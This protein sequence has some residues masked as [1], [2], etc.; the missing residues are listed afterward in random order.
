LQKATSGS[1][2][3]ALRHVTQRFHADI[4]GGQANG[5]NNSLPYIEHLTL[6]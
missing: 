4:I 1:L 2:H 3:K 5:H 6:F